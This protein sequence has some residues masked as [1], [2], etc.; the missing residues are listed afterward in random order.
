MDRWKTAMNPGTVRIAS[1]QGIKH[2]EQK[3]LQYAA[4][5]AYEVISKTGDSLSCP[6][7]GRPGTA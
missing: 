1:Y 2:A 6:N 4:D 5:K 3:I 7:A